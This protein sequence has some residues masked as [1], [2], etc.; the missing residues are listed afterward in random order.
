MVA[1]EELER[2]SSEM[3]QK[4]ADE[5]VEGLSTLAASDALAEMGAEAAST[6]IDKMASGKDTEEESK[7]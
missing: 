3:A 5:L 6:G 1:A 4:G 2:A 7:N